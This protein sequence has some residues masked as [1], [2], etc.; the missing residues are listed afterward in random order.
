MAGLEPATAGF[1]DRCS[2]QLSY[3]PSLT[4]GSLRGWS[5]SISGFTIPLGWWNSLPGN[6]AWLAQAS[7]V[8]RFLGSL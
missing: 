5:R 3:M 7:G 2:I 6:G 4:S 1:V 8:G